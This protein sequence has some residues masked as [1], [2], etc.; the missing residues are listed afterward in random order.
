MQDQT[1]D[2]P[3]QDLPPCLLSVHC[4]RLVDALNE[5]NN[6][7]RVEL[8]PSGAFQNTHLADEQL[9]DLLHAHIPDCPSCT[10]ALA[11][12]RNMRLRQRSA[13]RD[14]LVEGEQSVPST[15][16][17][18]MQ[19]IGSERRTTLS[20]VY[21]EE[22]YAGP[23]LF[24][25]QFQGSQNKLGASLHVRQSRLQWR[26]IFSLVAVVVV[27]LTSLGM[28]SHL[29]TLRTTTTSTLSPKASSLM[30]T[31][32]TGTIPVRPSTPIPT[33]SSWSK[34]L[35]VSNTSGFVGLNNLD[36]YNGTSSILEDTLPLDTRID[37][38]SPD[39]GNILYSSVGKGETTYW[40]WSKSAGSRIFY[41]L[42][43]AEAGNAIWQPDSR[44]VLIATIRKGVLQV[45]SETGRAVA[46]LPDLKTAGVRFYRYP[47][48]YFVG[49][50]NLNTGALYRINITDKRVQQVTERVSGTTFWLSPDGY[51]IYYV[52]KGSAGQPGIYEVDGDITHQRLLKRDGV[53]IGYAKDDALMI[54]RQ[55]EGKFQV[56]KLGATSL[57]DTVVVDDVAPGAV[58]LCDSSVPSGVSLLCDSNIALAPLG[59]S[60]V[61]AA[62]YPD[63]SHKLWSIDVNARRS[64][65]LTGFDGPS[66]LQLIGWNKIG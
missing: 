17:R 41:S 3:I 16:V 43:N 60:L 33:F 36:A 65:Q 5:Q 29:G 28:F 1:P 31:L 18:I 52:N 14:L 21:D 20:R 48:L 11:R 35:I 37:G 32:V 64:I 13:L 12:A 4:F 53:P 58:S 50:E 56:V 34:V 9:L 44:S 2:F 23:E 22:K 66:S 61:V 54:M 59:G 57:E 49:A 26:T 8:A 42:N 38:I 47:Y 27:I 45:D 24:P 30:S 39:G 46:L 25:I 63:G 19:A 10:T 6:G 55:F 51:T 40:V 7:L 15:T 62:S